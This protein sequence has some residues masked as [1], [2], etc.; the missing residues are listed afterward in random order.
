M[1]ETGKNVEKRMKGGNGVRLE[2]NKGES[3]KE[4]RERK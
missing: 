1:R 3:Q 2:E 4:S